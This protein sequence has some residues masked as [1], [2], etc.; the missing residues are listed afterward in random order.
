GVD[1][2]KLAL[3]ALS[4]GLE[5]QAA[6]QRVSLPAPLFY[7]L[8]RRALPTDLVALGHI[9]PQT[10]S[11]AATQA[12]D[13]NLIPATLR[14]SLPGL[15]EQL[16]QLAVGHALQTPPETGKPT[17]GQLLGTALTAA[18]DQA[19]FLRAYRSRG[20]QPIEEFWAGLR[21]DKQL[22]PKVEA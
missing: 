1:R 3:L 14:D 4:A 19:A 17:L 21:V 7:G 20:D 6:Q 13:Q 11:S 5:K 22:G 15:V 8:G 16:H 10:L 18:P 9:A 12:L 2:Q